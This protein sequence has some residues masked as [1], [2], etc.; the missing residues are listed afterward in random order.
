MAADDGLQ[1]FALFG[2]EQKQ[3]D[4]QGGLVGVAVHQQAGQPENGRRLDFNAADVAPCEKLPA[5]C[6]TTMPLG[7]Q[8]TWRRCRTTVNTMAS[9]TK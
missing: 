8:V 1:C 2:G 3:V 6:T 9:G 5:A 7:M 4:A